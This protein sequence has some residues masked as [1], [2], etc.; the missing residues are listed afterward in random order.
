IFGRMTNHQ[1][2]ARVTIRAKTS[3]LRISVTYQSGA[4]SR[5][6]VFVS[7]SPLTT[8]AVQTYAISPSQKAPFR[9]QSVAPVLRSF[10]RMTAASAGSAVT[11]GARPAATASSVTDNDRAPRSRAAGLGRDALP[12]RDAAEHRRVDAGDRADQV[13]GEL[14]AR[15][16]VD[17]AQEPVDGP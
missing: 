14:D 15:R 16:A 7:K 1:R 9:I 10:S 17:R 8:Q 4:R 13:A 3:Q 6:L 12:G 11:C 5:P 2:I